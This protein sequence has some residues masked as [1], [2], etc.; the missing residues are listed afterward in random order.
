VTERGSL[1]GV[2]RTALGV[3]VLRALHPIVDDRPLVLDDP[4]STVLFGDVARA[5]VDG[6]IAALLGDERANALRAHVLVR[7]AFA[8]ERLRQA[9]ARGVRQAV[10][11]GA[12]FDTFAYRQPP[13]MDGVRLFEVDAPATQ[14]D[15]RAR[16]AAAGI[17][18]PPNV[19]YAAIDFERT[20]LADGLRA[21]GLDLAAPAFFSLLGVMVYLTRD[22]IDAVF[23]TV[24]AMPP[25]SEIAFTFT[26][27][28]DSNVL[29]QRVG[30]LG[31][32]FRTSTTVAELE[33]LL[34]R[35]AFREHTILSP[36]EAQRYL[37]ARTDTLRFPPRASIA[38]A[39][40]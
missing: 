7:S 21:A 13:W 30:E 36:A 39:I 22:A 33:T 1:D 12:G 6:G 28:I 38:A 18:E 2:S 27:A 19:V 9:A 25:G 32:P 14:A 8:E 10:V 16:L 15:K 5:R 37:G 26:Q 31:E 11:L 3:G 40:V 35:H 17:A 20:A 24:A 34:D 4:I 23:R 29:A